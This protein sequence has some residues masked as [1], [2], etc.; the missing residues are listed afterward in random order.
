MRGNLMRGGGEKLGKE[1]L[2]Q[3]SKRLMSY[4]NKRYKFQF[5][6]VLLL[7]TLSAI[8]SVEGSRFIETLINEYIVPFIGM[9]SPNFASLLRAVL[10][11]AFIFG[12]GVVSIF[13]FNRIMVTISQGVQKEI[14]DELFSHMQKMKISYF[15]TNSHG[16]IMSR[17][18]NDVDTLR[19]L[20]GQ[21]IPVIF[22]SLLTMV[23]SLIAMVFMSGVLTS[24]MLLGVIINLLFTVNIGKKSGKFFGIQQKAIGELNGHI[25]ELITNQKVVKVFNYEEESKNKFDEFNNSVENAS[26]N[27]NKYANMFL[28]IMI[29][30]GTLQYVILA[31]VGGFMAINGL[32]T[33]G[34]IAAFLQL[35]RMFTMPLGN[36][37]MQ[38]NGIASALAGANRVF[39]ILDT[40][41]EKDKGTTLLT[42]TNEAWKWDENGEK[43]LLKG[44]V[45]LNNV[46]FGYTDE[47][48]V[49]DNI[50]LVAHPG[51]KIAIVGATGAGKTTITNLINR[52]YDIRKGEILYDNI[53]I[54]K[55]K[56]PDLRKSFGVVLQDSIL[57]TETVRE[58]IR[59]G[60][61][62]ATDEE[63]YEAARLAHAEEFINLLKDGYDTILE[64]AG[65]SLSQGQRQ[66]LCIA[67]AAIA[68]PPVMI[69]DEATSSIDTRTELIVQKGMDSLM[70]GRTVFV[71]AHR[72]STVKNADSI[73]VLENG[74]IIERGTH[75]ELLNNKET[76]H[77]MYTG[78][79]SFDD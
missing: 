79:L 2:I 4:I 5:M 21:G 17:Y 41:P 16:D 73:V 71:I 78:G 54:E 43:I 23:L 75:I 27:A 46:V 1:K 30:M 49:L 18:T 11:M 56:K 28:P 29:N 51:E 77:K 31:V 40:E 33:I 66:L 15:D 68:N 69:L 25:E 48:T 47:Q 12:I 45:V 6:L 76:Y 38:I 67:R 70:Q 65:A 59:Y 19:N 74:K 8:S 72:L 61:L 14:R 53:N 22:S 55:I 24:V 13:L 58:N 35:S 3:T 44:D 9:E 10:I 62:D 52:F 34:I 36:L 57:F 39:E 50:N 64:N 26:K 42:K 63:V 20:L 37:S 32:I 7:I 60:K